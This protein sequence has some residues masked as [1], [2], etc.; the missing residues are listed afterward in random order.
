MH[1]VV[2]QVVQ[3]QEVHEAHGHRTVECIARAAVVE[4]CLRLGGRELQ[5]LGFFIREGQVEHHADLFFARA[6]EHGRCKGHT[7]GKVLR[8]FHQLFVVEAVEIFLL[9]GAVVHLVQEGADL[10]GLFGLEHFGNTP[11]D[12]LGG[13]AQVHF[14][15]LTDV[16]TGR[17]AERVQADVGGTTVGHVRHV[18][19]RADLGDHTLVTVTAGHL[20][21]G[22]QT[23]LLGDEHLDHLQNARRQLVAAI[24]LV[25]LAG[26]EFLVF[27]ALVVDHLA[28]EI[29]DL[30]IFFAFHADLE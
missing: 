4:R 29:N 28:G 21:A 9:A 8:Q 17:H 22:L 30:L 10:R 27:F 13:P 24:E 20:V 14:E 1:L 12:T 18:F 15:N 23:A 2:D 26:K 3:L 19:D 25:A 11:A 5:L 7:V 16:H 6:V